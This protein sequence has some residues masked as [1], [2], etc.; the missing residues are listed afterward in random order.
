MKKKL[1]VYGDSFVAPWG[2][3]TMDSSEQI[4]WTKYLADLLGYDEVNRAVS[5]CSNAVI[6]SRIYNDI[7]KNI[8]HNDNTDVM[9]VNVSTNGRFYND[10]VITNNP[11]AGSTYL[12]ALNNELTSL[13]DNDEYFKNNKNHIKWAVLENHMPLEILTL[14]SFLFW[15]KYYVAENY[16][17]IKIIVM[18]VTAKTGVDL[19]S[20]KDTDNFI[21][22]SNF[23]LSEA[24]DREFKSG[25][26][27]YADFVKHTH[28]DPR[29]NH[30]T[31]PNRKKLADTM[32]NIIQNGD[33]DILHYDLFERGTVKTVKNVEQYLTYIENGLVEIDNNIMKRKGWNIPVAN[34][35]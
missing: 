15:L 12:G 22:C 16:P 20:L 34:R 33:K 28:I 11:G 26:K 8:I 30:F 27:N 14:E 18:F 25:T 4:N 9:I 6:F 5:G 2:T 24:S 17:N 10:H 32:F 13:V 3:P 29:A 35:N 31:T 21:C 19:N 7:K 1:R 23:F